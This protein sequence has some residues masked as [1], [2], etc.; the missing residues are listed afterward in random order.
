MSAPYDSFDYPNYWIGRNYEHE[1]EVYAI[2]ELLSK[3]DKIHTIA[4]IGAGY[5]RLTPVYSFRAKKIILIDPSLKLLRVAQK[6][7][8]NKKTLFINSKAENLHKKMR[9]STADLAILVRVLHHIKNPEKVFLNIS[10]ILKKRGYLIL[11]FPNKYHFKARI[12]EFLKGNLTFPIDI[13]TKDISSKKSKKQ[14]TLPFHNYHPDKIIEILK[15]CG[16]EIV[17]IRSVSN[18]RSPLVKKILSTHV[19]VEIEKKIQ[20]PLARAFFGPSL[21]ILAQKQG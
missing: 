20:K 11:E 13:S 12:I 4:E 17:E 18:I 19:L 7:T 15:N 14:K 3:I 2:G 1:S 5:G 6:S 8:K 10:R 16:F 21:F 9:A